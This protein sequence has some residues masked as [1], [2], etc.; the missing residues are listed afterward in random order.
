[1]GNFVKEKKI[2]DFDY[3]KKS[4]HHMFKTICYTIVVDTPTA[5]ISTETPAG[6]SKLE[7][8][9]TVFISDCINIDW[10]ILKF[11]ER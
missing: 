10:I 1:M 2:V 5:V 11:L 4:H 7:S 8:V 6:R 9:P 3:M